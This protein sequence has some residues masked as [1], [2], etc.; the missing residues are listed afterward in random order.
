M[1]VFSGQ[2]GM[3]AWRPETIP[4]RPSNKIFCAEITNYVPE[5]LREAHEALLAR[6]WRV[7]LDDGS[8][9][10]EQRGGADH[11]LLMPRHGAAW[12]ASP[13]CEFNIH[14][15]RFGSA[16][17]LAIEK[18]GGYDGSLPW[19]SAVHLD[20]DDFARGAELPWRSAHARP[21]LIGIA[22]GS[23][24][25]KVASGHADRKTIEKECADV[26]D[27]SVCRRVV[28]PSSPRLGYQRGGAAHAVDATLR[29]QLANVS[30]ELLHDSSNIAVGRESAWFWPEVWRSPPRRHGL[31][32]TV[33]LRNSLS[34]SRS[35][36]RREHMRPRRLLNSC[37]VLM[38]RTPFATHTHV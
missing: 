19:P 5:L 34:L 22:F 27:T 21:H 33:F 7:T 25:V 6:L 32:V 20:A 12:E 8:R 2:L 13:F 1:P 36:S 28:M 30:T 14:D 17:R 35:P 23:R 4:P 24:V 10:L 26:A 31:F 15:R 9:A 29:T 11:I 18:N 3:A 37:A 16:I 38:R